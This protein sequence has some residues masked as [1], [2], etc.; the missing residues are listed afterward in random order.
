MRF[1]LAIEAQGLTK[2]A[3]A[4][5]LSGAQRRIGFGGTWGRELS[6]WLNTELVDA[7]GLHA[8]DRNL[9][10]LRPLGIES[11]AVRFARA[12]ATGR[13]AAAARPSSRRPD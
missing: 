9:R 12:R 8:V 13:R 7:D 1:D 3:V 5:W 6:T 11:P 10:L 2:S 4:A